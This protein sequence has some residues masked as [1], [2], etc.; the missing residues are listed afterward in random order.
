MSKTYKDRKDYH[1]KGG[2]R[3][4][5]RNRNPIARGLHTPLY[6]PRRTEDK[7]DSIIEHLVKEDIKYDQGD[8][9]SETISIPTRLHDL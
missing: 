9:L 2:K 4:F 6:R 8:D 7:R 5:K 3:A 1:D